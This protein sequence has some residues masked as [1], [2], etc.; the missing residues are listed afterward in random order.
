VSA[1]PTLPNKALQ[2]PC[3]PPFEGPKEQPL[4]RTLFN[5]CAGL[6]AALDRELDLDP[7]QAP[8]ATLFL[9]LL[10]PITLS[11]N[12]CNA[13]NIA[14]LLQAVSDCLQQELRPALQSKQQPQERLDQQA[15]NLAGQNKN[16]V[17]QCAR[18]RIQAQAKRAQKTVVD[19]FDYKPRFSL[20]KNFKVLETLQCSGDAKEHLK[21]HKGAWQWPRSDQ[22]LQYHALDNFTKAGLYLEC[23]D[24]M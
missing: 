3:N 7:E 15:K 19:A 4:L 8:S 22:H 6:E 5:F 21:V 18:C 9:L 20:G 11:E 17:C 2:T 24:G 10:T 12:P 1:L 13:P 14:K 16:T 23:W